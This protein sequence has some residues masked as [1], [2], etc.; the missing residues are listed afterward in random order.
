M[1]VVSGGAEGSAVDISGSNTE[2]SGLGRTDE[3][4]V[5][6]FVASSSSKS[7]SVVDNTSTST[8][9]VPTSNSFADTPEKSAQ[10]QTESQTESS[11]TP[12]TKEGSTVDSC[13]TDSVVVDTAGISEVS[14]SSSSGSAS[15][16]TTPIKPAKV[17]ESTS[18]IPEGD[19]EPSAD[20]ELKKLRPL[21]ARRQLIAQK[22]SASISNTPTSDKEKARDALDDLL[23]EAVMDADASQ[24]QKPTVSLT[25]SA[26]KMKP[27]TIAEIEAEVKK[28]TEEFDNKQLRGKEEEEEDKEEQTDKDTKGGDSDTITEG[29]TNSAGTD[30]AADPDDHLYIPTDTSTTNTSSKGWLAGIAPASAH[31]MIRLLVIGLLGW[32]SGY[33]YQ[34]SEQLFLDDKYTSTITGGA[35]SAYPSQGAE[36]PTAMVEQETKMWA[37]MLKVSTNI[38]VVD[39]CV[40]SLYVYN[41][42]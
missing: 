23:D 32:Y 34:K 11:P 10:V 25:S 19:V 29:T 36:P 12:Y 1:H 4:P 37:E 16:T 35:P 38:I 17:D 18:P 24:N 39:I 13:S 6:P 42:C 5:N 20:V 14:P 30:A 21:A 9:T 22:A 27:K 33:S 2:S 41:I 8:T 31:K 26:L 40:I 7:A 28:A 15:S 3:D